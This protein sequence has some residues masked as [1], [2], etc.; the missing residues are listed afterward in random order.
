MHGT[1][2][3]SYR[4]TQRWLA[5]SG[6]G[7]ELSD[8]AWGLLSLR[9]AA[10]SRAVLWC[11]PLFLAAVGSLG[12]A[13]VP[14]AE[15]GTPAWDRR[16]AACF[17]LAIGCLAVAT[18]VGNL[19]GGAAER[20][21]AA[22]LPRRVSRAAAVPLRVIL[23]GVRCIFL[24]TAIVLEAASAVTLLIT[25]AGWLAPVYLAAVCA[26]DAWVAVVLRRAANRPTI[27]LDASSLAIDE[28]LRSLDAFSAAGPLY[29][30]QLAFPASLIFH[31][32]P[33]WL[34]LPWLVEFAIV[35]G[36][37]ILAQVSNPWR[38]ASSRTTGPLSTAIPGAQR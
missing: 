17:L 31:A 6:V 14:T 37:W 36:L 32:T 35:S 8:Q 13:A 15:S 33:Q 30:L 22:G 28:R 23:G 34:P 27:A 16:F 20:R 29:L 5:A 12:W 7:I 26:I 11:A 9:L 2:S 1:N 25:H 38:A 21:I 18:I 10:R 3:R 4:R 19:L 24:V